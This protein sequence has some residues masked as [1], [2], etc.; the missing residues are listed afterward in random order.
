MDKIP[1][2]KHGHGKLVKELEDRKTVDRPRIVNAIAEARAHGDLSE[3]AEYKAAREEQSFNEGRIKDLEG[4]IARAEVIDAT[5]LSGDMVKFG[6]T[7]TLEE[8]E[9]GGEECY[10][11]VGEDEAEIDPSQKKSKISYS[12]P[13]ARA[14]IGKA[15]GDTVTVKLPSAKTKEYEILRIQ[16]I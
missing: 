8:I 5:T 14:M 4:K 3:N 9:N 6:A 13:V 16:F 1:M 10:Q 7:V 11:I 12:S 15:V 2:T